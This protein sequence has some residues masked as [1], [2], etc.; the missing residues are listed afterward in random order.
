MD[1]LVFKAY[2]FAMAAH[3]AVGQKRNYGDR[4]YI[5]HP[6]EVADILAGYGA[7]PVVL[8]A[9]MLHDVLEDTKV[10][11]DLLVQEFGQEVA[12][13][14]R[15]VSNV[16]KPADGNRRERTLVNLRHKAKASALGHD[17]AMGD[18]ISNIPTL[19]RLSPKFALVYIPEKW[20]AVT[21]LTKGN[22]ELR[23]RAEEVVRKAAQ[24][25]G[26]TL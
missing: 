16:A 2:I 7:G 6:K 18:I 8:A 23:Q 20:L 26:I 9:C 15:M 24:E 13:L 19:P 12:D 4:P 1:P 21:T 17:I 22:P 14:V 10:T 3:A 25:L 11:F 5:E